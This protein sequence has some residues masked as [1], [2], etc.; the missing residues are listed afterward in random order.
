MITHNPI[1]AL[2]T[3]HGLD[4][5]LASFWVDN[6]SRICILLALQLCDFTAVRI[7]NWSATGKRMLNVS[8]TLEPAAY[9]DGWSWQRSNIRSRAIATQ[10]ILQCS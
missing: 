10:Q 8:T 5:A 7:Y 1:K 4:E 9:A 3:H 6:L 2:L